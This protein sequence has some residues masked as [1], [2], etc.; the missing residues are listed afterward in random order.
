MDIP[1]VEKQQGIEIEKEHTPTI[2]NIYQEAEGREPSE[3]ELLSAFEGIV[4]DHEKETIDITSEPVYYEKYLVPMEDKMKA[5][6]QKENGE[7]TMKINSNT[8]GITKESSEYKELEDIITKIASEN[9][10]DNVE[11]VAISLSQDKGIIGFKVA[12]EGVPADPSTNPAVISAEQQASAAQQKAT[13]ASTE[14]QTAQN[15]VNS[16]KQ[17][18]A[19]QTQ[20][21]QS[22]L[23]V[24]DYA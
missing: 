15:A 9:K 1:K 4:D 24:G 22:G 23:T 2:T 6:G 21:Q 18:A 11:R 10:I 13:Q 7:N 14:L 20:Q 3:E 8:V 19:T 5:D 16:A 17:Q 12:Q